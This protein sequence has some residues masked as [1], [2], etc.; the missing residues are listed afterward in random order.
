MPRIARRGGILVAL[1]S[2]HCSGEGCHAARAYSADDR[3]G[4]ITHYAAESGTI[5]KLK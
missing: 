1:V 5:S 2:I 4:W 3:Y